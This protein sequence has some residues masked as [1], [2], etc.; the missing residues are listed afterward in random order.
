MEPDIVLPHW[1]MQSIFVQR[2]SQQPKANRLIKHVR[3]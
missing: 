1:R 2:I 3:F